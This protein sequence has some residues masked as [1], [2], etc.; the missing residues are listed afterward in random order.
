MSAVI[1]TFGAERGPFVCETVKRLL[2][3]TVA[4]VEVIVVDQ[5]ELQRPSVRELLTKWDQGDQ[6]RW[7]RLKEPSLPHARNVGIRGARGAV[8]LFVDDDVRFADSLVE[9][10]QRNYGGQTQVDMVA[11]QLRPSIE[12]EP[13]VGEPDSIDNALEAVKSPKHYDSR[14]LNRV[15]IAGGNF[16]VKASTALAVGGFDE[17]FVGPAIYEDVDFWLRVRRGGYQVVFDPDAWAVGRE[18]AGG[19]R[20][21]RD[22]RKA[23]WC[24]SYFACRHCDLPSLSFWR[25][26]LGFGVRPFVLNSETLGRPTEMLSRL[27][28]L[29]E[30]IREAYNLSNSGKGVKS[31]FAGSAEW[32]DMPIVE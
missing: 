31:P 18:V 3:Q 25:F 15:P 21:F 28:L 19:T 6:I 23:L 2:A 32:P 20:S 30:C 24:V 8:I 22:P 4:P 5:T 13:L 1:P 29:G 26:I 10:H 27:R 7:I 14:C 12:F 17:H 9:R 16:S 11:G